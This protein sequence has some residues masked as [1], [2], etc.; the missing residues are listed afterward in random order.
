MTYV[1]MLNFV[2][3]A[4]GLGV[5]WHGWNQF[6]WIDHQKFIKEAEQAE[7]QQLIQSAS[8]ILRGNAIVERALGLFALGNLVGMTAWFFTC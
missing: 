7:N 4:T 1:L 8:Q 2:L 6:K 5:T 3:F